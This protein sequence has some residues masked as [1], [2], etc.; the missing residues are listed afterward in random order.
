ML[1]FI[2]K[3]RVPDFVKSL[4]NVKKYSTTVLFIF[5]SVIYDLRNSVN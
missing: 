3:S 1:N 5:K 4:T 2:N